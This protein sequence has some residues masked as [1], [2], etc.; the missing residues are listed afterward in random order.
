MLSVPHYRYTYYINKNK[1]TKKL[2]EVIKMTGFELYLRDSNDAPLEG[3]TGTLAQTM[4][5]IF[6]A[7][8]DYNFSNADLE[9]TIV[10]ISG[11]AENGIRY[12]ELPLN[13]IGSFIE[14]YA[15]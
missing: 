4:Q 11:M 10:R 3:T 13:S 14:I 5:F 1:N 9:A 15:V 7:K 8:R 12:Q 6:D 2:E